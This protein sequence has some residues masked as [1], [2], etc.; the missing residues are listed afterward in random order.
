MISILVFFSTSRLFKKLFLVDKNL[1]SCLLQGLM[2]N[3]FLT[4]LIFSL[5]RFLHRHGII[6]SKIKKFKV[7]M[8]LI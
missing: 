6:T 7:T 2:Y 4:G 1:F 3:V 8:T 5:V